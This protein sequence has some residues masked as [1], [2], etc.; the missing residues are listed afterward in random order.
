MTLS[1]SVA[2]CTYNGA[3]FIERQI[4]SILEQ[5]QSPFELV[6]ADDGSTDDTLQIIRRTC[7]RY[8][9]STTVLRILGPAGHLGVTGNFERAIVATTGDLIALADQDDIWHSDRVSVSVAA[10]ELDD[11]LLL[12]HGDATLVGPA[13]EPLGLGLLEALSVGAAEFQAIASERAF[14]TYLRRNLV[15]GATV[16]FRRSLIA[17]ALPFSRDWVHDEWLAMIASAIGSVQLNRR[18]LIDYRQHGSNEIGV[19]APTIGYRVRRMLEPR[20][21]H[22]VMLAR[23]ADALLAVLRTLGVAERYIVLA[24]R[25][26]RFERVRASLPAARLARV[27]PVIR[28]FHAGSY[29]DLSSQRALDVVR[30]IIQPA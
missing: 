2:L 1:V 14:D 20:G 13:G 3:A 17:A 6:V 5:D 24:E 21:Q 18:A 25:K 10:F 30:D 15:T 26:L 8:V 19:A 23:R 28:E 11:T 22:Y 4:V 27:R 7:E 12:Q 16:M 9:S 29:T